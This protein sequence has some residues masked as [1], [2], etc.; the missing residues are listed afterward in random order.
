MATRCT[1]LNF[2]FNAIA[3]FLLAFPVS[4]QNL[5][6]SDLADRLDEQGIESIETY[7]GI[8]LDTQPDLGKQPWYS[9]N[10]QVNGDIKILR[11][12]EYE[13]QRCREIQITITKGIE[14]DI[15]TFNYCKNDD[16][17]WQHL[18]YIWF[19]SD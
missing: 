2:C 6:P 19:K 14:T 10:N 12:F 17:E 8:A 1:K 15:R 7:I 18:Q 16:L 3:T 5:I 11:S 13:L 9:T 4:A